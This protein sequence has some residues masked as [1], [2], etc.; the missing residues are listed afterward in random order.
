MKRTTKEQATAFR[1]RWAMVNEAE[2]VEL[3]Q[4]PIA[5]KL[6]QTAA[7]MAS[8]QAMGWDDTIGVDESEVWARWQRLRARYHG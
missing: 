2:I 7:L 8:V 5:E 3:R 6:Q 1:R 4:T